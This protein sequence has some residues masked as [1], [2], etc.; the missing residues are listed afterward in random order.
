[1]SA[2][3]LLPD[4]PL[5]ESATL[6]VHPS[7]SVPELPPWLRDMYP[8][9]TCKVAIGNYSMSLVDEGPADAAPLL[10]LHGNPGWSFSFRKL[11]GAVSE[12]Y[13][14]IVPDMVGFGLS[15]KPTDP[16]YHTLP[17]HIDNLAVLVER[18]ELRQITLLLHDWGGPVG[19]GYAVAH[20]ENIARIVATNTWAFPMPNRNTVRLPFG[21][22]LARSSGLGRMLD[23]LLSLSITSAL[24]AGSSAADDMTVEGYKYPAHGPAGCVATRAFW[25]MLGSGQADAELGRISRGLSRITAPLEILWGARDRLFSRLPAYMLRDA[26]KNATDPVFLEAASHYVAEDAPET[27]ISKLLEQ[28]KSTLKLKIIG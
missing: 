19:F 28:R 14:V 9:R 13:R 2:E 16:E 3:P 10:M 6:K 24:S 18:L 26:V 17:R 21:V 15:D 22:R 20:P 1:M 27:L 23:S 8:F 11:I 25:R 5:S 4:P 7:A 12:R